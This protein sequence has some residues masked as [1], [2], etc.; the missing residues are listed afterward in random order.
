MGKN[1]TVSKKIKNRITVSFR[2]STSGN[3]RKLN[4]YL[5]SDVHSNIIRNSQKMETIQMS[6]NA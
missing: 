6:I 1:M 4:R 2:N 3:E 5:Y